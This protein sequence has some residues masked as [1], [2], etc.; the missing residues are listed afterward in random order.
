M[1]RARRARA[2]GSRSRAA[3]PG[4]LVIALVGASVWRLDQDEVIAPVAAATPEAFVNADA[5]P[6]I[7]RADTY[8]AV[9]ALEDHIAQRRRRAQRARA[10]T[11]RAATRSRGSSARAPSCIDSYAQVRYAEMVSANF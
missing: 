2:A 8:F 10:S 1:P 5:Q 9:A 7:V 6:R 4:A 11:R 3:P